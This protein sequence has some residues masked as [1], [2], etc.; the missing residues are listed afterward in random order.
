[1][2]HFQ[3]VKSTA[4]ADSEQILRESIVVNKSP[5]EIGVQTV[6]SK[7]LICVS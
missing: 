6:P 7:R 2:S 4:T 5:I 1:M 3:V